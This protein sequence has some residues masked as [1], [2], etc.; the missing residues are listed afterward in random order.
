LAPYGR[1]ALV[2]IDK[3]ELHG[4]SIHPETL[5]HLPTRPAAARLG[6]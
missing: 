2:Q 5:L 3:E 1:P 6:Q 4:C